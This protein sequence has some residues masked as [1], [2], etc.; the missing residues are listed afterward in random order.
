MSSVKGCI[1]MAGAYKDPCL[2]Y[3]K[4][5]RDPSCTLAG[6]GLSYVYDFPRIVIMDPLNT[7]DGL[8]ILSFSLVSSNVPLFP[9]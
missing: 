5:C 9:V 4:E 3:S 1:E 2:L 8:M 7:I 6:P